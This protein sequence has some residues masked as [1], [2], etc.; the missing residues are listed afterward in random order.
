[1]C[2]CVVGSISGVSLLSA[3]YLIYTFLFIQQA[4]QKV[5]LSGALFLSRTVTWQRRS[6][7]ELFT[8]PSLL[9]MAGGYPTFPQPIGS[10]PSVILS[11]LSLLSAAT[12]AAA[13]PEVYRKDIADNLMHA[14][15]T[16]MNMS[17][18]T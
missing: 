7:A 13:L 5:L 9:I 4:N 8:I 14:V 10:L 3:H 17:M 11:V 15:Q 6:P 16:Y 12:S 18:Y 1:M 2:V